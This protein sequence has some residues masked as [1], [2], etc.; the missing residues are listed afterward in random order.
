MSSPAGMSLIVRMVTRW[1]FGLIL[2]YGLA[3]ALFGHLTPG[4]GFAGGTI[5]A[6]AFVLAILAFGGARGPGARFSRWA[7]TLDAAAALAFLL[8]GLLG[9][10]AGTFLQ[11]WT[12]RGELFTLGGT[13]SIVLLNLV[14]LLKVGA[15][16][17]A[18]FV[19][20]ALFENASK[21][22]KGEDA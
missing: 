17:F 2:I 21:P 5:V 1:L 10:M 14:I 22:E 6:A 8:L 3:I 11:Q 4:G 9:F 20:V 13:P 12:G 19:A 18:G 7:S 15:G 16:L